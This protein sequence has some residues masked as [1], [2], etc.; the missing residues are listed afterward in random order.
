M[1]GL[2]YNYKILMELHADKYSIETMGSPVHLGEALL[3]L[4]K[5]DADDVPMLV[6]HFEKTAIDYRISH[7]LEP[8]RFVPYNITMKSTFISLIGAS[9]FG[10]LVF[11]GYI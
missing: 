10:M 7:I 6:V 8:H 9:A 3:K 11:S 5:T 2:S 4:V 1:K